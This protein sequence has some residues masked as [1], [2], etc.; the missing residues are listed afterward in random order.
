[1]TTTAEPGQDR[2]APWQDAAAC[3]QLDTE[4]FFPIGSGGLSQAD[5]RQAKAVCAHCPVRPP[6]LAYAVATRQ[7]F[8]IWG[9]LD[10]QERRPLYRHWPAGGGAGRDPRPDA[11]LR[12]ALRRT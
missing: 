9:G 4:M 11:D 1:M 12:G 6:C 2:R 5:T 7:E 3:R 10:E 8:G